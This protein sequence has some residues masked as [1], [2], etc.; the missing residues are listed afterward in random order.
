MLKLKAVTFDRAPRLPGIRAGDLSMLDC[1]NPG[2][3][4]GWRI[5]LR[6]P[7]MFLI[8]PPGWTSSENRATKRDSKGPMTV[9]EIPRSGVFFQWA[10]GSAED[11]ENVLKSGKWESEPLGPKPVA[12]PAEAATKI[13]ASEMGDA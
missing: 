4:T 6:G 8:S 1:D 10:V 5:V 7:A 13:P 12:A 11:M 3:L 9:Y 2:S